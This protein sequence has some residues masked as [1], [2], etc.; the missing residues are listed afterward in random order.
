MI[1]GSNDGIVSMIA[2]IDSDGFTY[3]HISGNATLAEGDGSEYFELLNIPV[4]MIS[5]GAYPATNDQGGGGSV[6]VSMSG[7]TATVS[8][9]AGTAGRAVYFS[10][11]LSKRFEEI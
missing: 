2:N 1:L 11:L 8:F 7:T 5:A 3:V 9:N 6:N 10:V 4:G